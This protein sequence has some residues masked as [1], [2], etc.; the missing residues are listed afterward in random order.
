MEGGCFTLV[1]GK[2]TLLLR[3]TFELGND[4]VDEFLGGAGTWVAGDLTER[5]LD[6]FEVVFAAHV[7]QKKMIEALKAIK[8]LGLSV[9]IVAGNVVIAMQLATAL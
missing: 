6:F 5:L 4:C 1:V 2:A 7:D 9:P 3:V 8:S